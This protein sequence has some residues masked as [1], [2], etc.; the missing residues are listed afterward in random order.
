MQTEF[1]AAPEDVFRGASPFLGA[2]ILDLAREQAR[3][4][5]L[6]QIVQRARVA[7]DALDARA[8]SAREAGARG[9]GQPWVAP[10]DGAQKR[11]EAGSLSTATHTDLREITARQECI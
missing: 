11:R 6:P 10:L 4:Y 1:A 8:V 2:Q 9:R 3:Q 7:D 5:F